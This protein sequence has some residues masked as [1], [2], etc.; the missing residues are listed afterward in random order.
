M[1]LKKHIPIIVLILLS[2]ALIIRLIGITSESYWL[3]EAVSIKQAQENYSTAIEMV[4]SDI[5]LP[6]YT[7]LLHFWVKLFGITEL[8]S[9]SLSLMFGVLS[10][11]MVYLLARKLFCEKIALISLALTAVSPI[12]TYYSQEARL[13]SLFV[14]LV[15]VSFYF[16]IE[17]I[18]KKD[19]KNLLF[20]LF[21]SLLLIYT[22][23]FSFLVI[24]AQNMYVLY[25]YRFKIKKLLK[26]FL[27]QLAL[28]ML[29]TPWIPTL[30]KQVNRT[31]SVMWIPKPNPG[32]V[33]KTFV[34]FFGNTLNLLIFIFVLVVIIQRK[35]FEAKSKEN[36]ILLGIW[37][38]VPFAIVIAYSSMFS[39][40]YNTRYL[41][42]TLPAILM[43]F[44]V[45]IDK[46]AEKN[47]TFSYILI[48]ILIISS[49]NSVFTQL[50]RM[51]KDD[52]RDVSIYV[53]E[54]VKE[55]ETIFIDP[56][57]HQQP[58]TYY[59]DIDCF[60][61]SDIPTCNFNRHEILSLDW[62]ATCCSD[63]SK[64][65]SNSGKNAL[66]DYLDKNVW[67]ISDRSWMYTTM[68][69]ESLFKYINNRKKL[70]ASYKIGDI[71]IYKFE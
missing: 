6:L 57:Y 53:K 65:T 39:S 32:I 58:F 12:M 47:K 63:N 51:D 44:S 1:D 11:F 37:I 45:F 30:I 2:I 70:T 69:N 20:Y 38:L 16:F 25:F 59:Y 27:C 34:E 48:A 17:Y 15:L 35:K 46:I 31:L 7:V 28:F 19:N 5:H 40:V 54:N 29:F 41:L 13:Y 62:E 22:H 61:E 52:W 68:P 50:E 67:L 3:D 9:R 33:I 26:W 14:L 55:N 10:L 21:F 8:S 24:I 60:K 49:L 36:I 43:L 56:F 66:S 64:L 71:E 23:L 4:K 42:F 18:E